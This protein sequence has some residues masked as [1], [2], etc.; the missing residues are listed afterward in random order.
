MRYA[1]G[2]SGRVEPDEPVFTA[3]ATLEATAEAAMWAARY[4]TAALASTPSAFDRKPELRCDNTCAE[5]MPQLSQAGIRVIACPLT[6][7]GFRRSLAYLKLCTMQYLL[8]K[9]SITKTT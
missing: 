6:A 8:G 7:T 9:P 5:P 3:F 2:T 1:A 4:S